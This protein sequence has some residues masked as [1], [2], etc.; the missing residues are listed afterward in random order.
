MPFCRI[1]NGAVKH[2]DGLA[3]H[4]GLASKGQTP[5]GISLEELKQPEGGRMCGQDTAELFHFFKQAQA[6]A[7]SV[8]D[9]VIS[10][11]LHQEH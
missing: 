2:P 5:S 11:V 4:A 6:Y 8:S 1:T 10:C 9:E 3:L 7:G